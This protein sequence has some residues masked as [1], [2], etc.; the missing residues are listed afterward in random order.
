LFIRGS[1]AIL[2]FRYQEGELPTGKRSSS[3]LKVFTANCQLFISAIM[4]T[5]KEVYPLDPLI[6]KTIIAELPDVQAIYRYG[7]AGSVYERQ[8]SDIDIAILASHIVPF[9]KMTELTAMLMDVTEHDVDLNDMQKLPVTLRVQ[10]ILQ[11]ERIFCKDQVAAETYDSH[12][13]SDYVRLNEERQ[14]I[15]K[16][17]QQR[18]QIYG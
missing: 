2:S 13:L 11:G 4:V 15:L 6:I 18:E 14:Y 5:M 12:T 8:D 3:G 1:L 17:I 16:D 9:Q 10:I 7:S